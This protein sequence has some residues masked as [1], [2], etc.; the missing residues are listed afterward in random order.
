MN[1]FCDDDIGGLLGLNTGGNRYIS[2]RQNM[3]PPPP[4]G[5][6]G[7]SESLRKRGGDEY[8]MKNT[9]SRNQEP[10]LGTW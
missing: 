10:K 4:P 2:F 6:R 5:G 3:P 1:I 9:R 7:D 8:S